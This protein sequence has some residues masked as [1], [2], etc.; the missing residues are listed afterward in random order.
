[1]NMSNNAA[2]GTLDFLPAE[3][4]GGPSS[5]LEFCTTVAGALHDGMSAARHYESLTARGVPPGEAVRAVFDNH[6]Q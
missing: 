4:T 6:F 1:M 5:F 2:D 3:K